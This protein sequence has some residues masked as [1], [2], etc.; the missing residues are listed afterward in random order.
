MTCTEDGSSKFWEGIWEGS[1]VT[2]KWGRIGTDGQEK[3]KEFA[4]EAAAEK[5]YNKLIKEK[6]GK[7]YVDD[8]PAKSV[9]AAAGGSKAAAKPAAAPVKAKP[10]PAPAKKPA[11][12]PAKAAGGAK[13]SRHLECTEDGASKF[14]IGELDGANFTTTWGKIGTDG[15][16]KT[17][18]FA[19]PDAAAKEYDKLVK[20]KLGK[21]YADAGE[22]AHGDD[23][24]EDDGDDFE[25]DDD[26]D[27]DDD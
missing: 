2:T 4:S 17:K 18:T 14:W 16:S 23:D 6:L 21:G 1:A 19:S 10:A 9:K 20:E 5:E 13:K 22:V 7:G 24:F 15:Q 25:D 11:P 26:D 3:T 27:G 8:K 12:A